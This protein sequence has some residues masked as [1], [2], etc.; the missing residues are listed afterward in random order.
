M[1]TTTV[2]L[3]LWNE[4]DLDLLRLTNAPD[5]TEH[6][7]GPESEQELLDRHRRYVDLAGTGTGEM[8]SIWADGEAAPVGSIGYWEREWRGAT[9]YEGGWN[10]LRPYQGRGLAVAA[11]N[12]LVERAA[13]RRT[14][15]YLHGYPKVDNPASNAVCRRAGWEL[16]GECDFEY[17][18]GTPIRCNDWRIALTAP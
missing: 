11:V 5:Q 4:G 14:H 10:V 16:L 18:A 1:T 9:V 8:F 13:A 12:A 15:E 6:F 3:E 17:P 2:R 7:G